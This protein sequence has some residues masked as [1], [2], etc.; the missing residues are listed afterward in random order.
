MLDRPCITND[1]DVLPGGERVHACVRRGAHYASC[2]NPDE[3]RGCVPRS[4]THGYL[5][6]VCWEKTV[7]ALSRVAW[8]IAHLRSI[9]SQGSALGE[10]VSTSPERRMLVPDSWLAADGL[11]EALG[12]R[13]IPST[14]SI[15]EAV[16]LAHDAV[17]L[18]ADVEDLVNT[19]AGAMNA[20]TLVRRMQ[21]ALH[22]W[23]NAEAEFRP[24]PFMLCPDCKQRSLYRRAPLEYLD[25]L[26]VQCGT[27]GCGYWEDWE[28]WAHFYGPILEELLKVKNRADAG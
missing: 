14:A 17:A 6:V 11:M 13:V 10:R 20:L 26:I 4:A 21:H 19:E 8:L 2:E 27:D 25:E 3:C 16:R 23:P 28:D 22:R 15:D 24:I 12:A 18:W 1:L 9:E 5:C 7:D